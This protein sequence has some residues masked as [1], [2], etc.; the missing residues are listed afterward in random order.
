MNPEHNAL[1]N[2]QHDVLALPRTQRPKPGLQDAWFVSKYTAHFI[3][4]PV[5][6]FRDL[7]YAVVPFQRCI[8]A[9]LG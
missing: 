6:K 3:G 2:S 9:N 4:R 7:S 1:W 8:R 5:P